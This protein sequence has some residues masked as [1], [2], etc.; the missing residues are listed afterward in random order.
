MLLLLLFLCS[1]C[2]GVFV[3]DVMIALAT[4]V[5][6]LHRALVLSCNGRQL[7]PAILHCAAI[8]ATVQCPRLA[9]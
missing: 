1:S 6:A 4:G 2:E 3:D 9:T 8:F 5:L 7:N